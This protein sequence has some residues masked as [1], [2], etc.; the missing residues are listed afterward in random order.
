MFKVGDKVRITSVKPEDYGKYPGWTKEMNEHL[1]KAGYIDHVVASSGLYKVDVDDW[2][3]PFTWKER[4]LTLITDVKNDNNMDGIELPGLPEGYR[5]VRVGKVRDGEW[6]LVAGKIAKWSYGDESELDFLVVD[7]VEP[8]L[9]IKV[10]HWYQKRNGAVTKVIR[11]IR[12]G[13]SLYDTG[14]RFETQDDYVN[15]YGLSRSPGESEDDLIREV[16]V[17]GADEEVQ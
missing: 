12:E 10:G 16:T 1:G 7:K 8:R 2:D 6:Y 11:E 5:A 9:E 3:I 15:E 17:I 14:W 13:T 4:D